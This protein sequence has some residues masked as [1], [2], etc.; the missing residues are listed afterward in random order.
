HHVVNR[1]G[2]FYSEFSGHVGRLE[3]PSRLVNK[4]C[5]NAGLTPKCVKTPRPRR[6]PSS[7]R[8][9]SDILANRRWLA[10]S[11]RSE[12]G[13]QIRLRRT[14]ARQGTTIRGQRTEDGRHRA[15]ITG[16][17]GRGKR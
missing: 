5:V 16:R 17:L 8:F 6:D 4:I 11:Q 1:S 2:I 13:S 7:R 12:I 3:E 14:S 15:A 10:R 9:S